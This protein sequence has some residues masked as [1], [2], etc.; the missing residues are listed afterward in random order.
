MGSL[1]H[2]VVRLGGLSSA[3]GAIAV[4]GRIGL[5]L[6]FSLI[7][8]AF[9]LIAVLALTGALGAQDN[10]DDAQTVLAILLGRNQSRGADSPG[11][12]PAARSV[13]PGTRAGSHP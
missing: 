12:K 9:I 13:P 1:K 2:T 6:A 7:A 8:L 5:F 11:R 10:R 4:P 3:A